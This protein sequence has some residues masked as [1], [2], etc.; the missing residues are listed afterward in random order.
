VRQA[1]RAASGVEEDAAGHGEDSVLSTVL[2]E[3]LL[4]QMLS[5][6]MYIVRCMPG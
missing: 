5:Q 3:V 6:S 2:R 1:H 4:L